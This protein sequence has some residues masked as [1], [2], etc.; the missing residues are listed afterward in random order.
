MKLLIVGS[1]AAGLSAAI[2][3]HTAGHEVVVVSKS[4]A[5]DSATAWA[6]GGIAAAIGP[7][8]SI[9]AHIDDTVAAGAGLS[10]E[11]AAEAL[12][13]AGPDTVGRLLALGMPFDRA[14]TGEIALGLEAAHSAARIVH[15]GGD[16]TGLALATTLLS[17]VQQLGIDIREE[18]FLTDLLVAGGR[19][20][21]ASFIINNRAE[22]IAA[23]AVVLATG[24][25]G[26]IFAHTTNPAIAT[27]DGIAAALRI[28]AQV[29]GLE[30]FQF[31][32]TTLAAPG[33][34][35]I[36][37]AVR[38]EG[39]LLLDSDGHR[40]MTDVDARGELAPRDVVARE[41]A[42]A[43]RRGPV[44]LDA[45]AL[46]WRFLAHR[47][48]TIDA[49]TRELG[50]DWARAPIPVTPAAHYLMGGIV[51]DEWGRT[52]VSGLLAVGETANS[53][54]H[55]ANRLA[56]N[57][58]LEALVFGERAVAAASSSW[59]S[60]PVQAPRERR[61]VPR[62]A[63]HNIM[64]RNAALERNSEGLERAAAALAALDGSGVAPTS[65]AELES[66]N[67]LEVA[68]ALV[69]SALALRESRGAHFRSDFS[70]TTIQ[71]EA[72]A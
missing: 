32:P 25:A 46:G 17:A 31:H 58:L 20:A 14:S 54:V 8:D 26:Q 10:T 1:G 22:T 19:V 24:G 13:A 52:S 61:A 42:R 55:G 56:S 12:C 60:A 71:E 51:T 29:A 50:F 72:L 59:G 67:L 16:A 9:R 49:R 7:D 36:S 65:V 68:S 63:V 47:F 23:D 34:F 70:R 57:S 3:A 18:A 30:F 66:A 35:L 27:G 4:S 33:N 5:L 2:A 69:A 40:F 28:G 45:T 11:V 21:G 38:G 64:W 48:P 6:Q 39:A 15:A 53:G 44:W 37:E 41:I 43:L 62:A